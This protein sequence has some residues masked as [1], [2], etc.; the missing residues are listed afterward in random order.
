MPHCRNCG[1]PVS[2]ADRECNICGS[3]LIR[4]KSVRKPLLDYKM[5]APNGSFNIGHSRGQHPTTSSL[6]LSSSKESPSRVW[7]P[8]KVF[9]VIV[10][11]A[12]LLPLFFYL[13]SV[14]FTA[15]FAQPSTPTG[16]FI[17][18]TNE[19]NITVQATFDGFYPETRYEE[20]DFTL[21]I[22]W[23]TSSKEEVVGGQTYYI[24]SP[25]NDAWIHFIDQG[26]NGV[27]EAGDYCTIQSSNPPIGTQCI[28]TIYYRPT[29][30]SICQAWFSFP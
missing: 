28:L 6:P 5:R 21:T 22:G 30:E 4:G 2:R 14:A 23:W 9:A 18:V 10:A 25:D 20:C 16:G 26:M 27:I 3:M 1:N 11:L 8:A 13:L 7:S 12:L 19:D 15:P 17:W 29:G 24:S